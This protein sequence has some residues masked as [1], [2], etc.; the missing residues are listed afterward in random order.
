MQMEMNKNRLSLLSL[1][2]QFV[3][4]TAPLTLHS[5]SRRPLL[6]TRIENTARNFLTRVLRKTVSAFP[7]FDFA[8]GRRRTRREGLHRG[9]NG[10]AENEKDRYLAK[11]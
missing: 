2:V 6:T 1:L 10:N 8:R 5:P 3:H 11:D 9:W 7:C 4:K